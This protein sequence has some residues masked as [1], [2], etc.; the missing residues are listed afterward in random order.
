MLSACKRQSVV[1]VFEIGFSLSKALKSEFEF[2]TVGF[3]ALLTFLNVTR[4]E[5]TCLSK[6][7]CL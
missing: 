7:V 5:G 2:E 6:Y 1:V 3:R 4:L